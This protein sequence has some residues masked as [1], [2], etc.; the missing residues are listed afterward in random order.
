MTIGTREPQLQRQGCCTVIRRKLVT[1][2]P[3]L[4][5]AADRTNGVEY[6][7]TEPCNVP[8]FGPEGRKA[9]QCRSCLGSFFHEHNFPAGVPLTM[10]QALQVA[11]AELLLPGPD[12]DLRITI[13]MKDGAK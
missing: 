11:V 4:A 10:G 13:L 12:M 8:L 9:G 2:F 1:G 7:V 6:W 3:T 5:D